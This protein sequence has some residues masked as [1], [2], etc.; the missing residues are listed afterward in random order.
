M[1]KNKEGRLLIFVTRT[2]EDGAFGKFYVLRVVLRRGT[3]GCCVV[4]ALQIPGFT[5]VRP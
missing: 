2:L 1:R 3:A 5:S 4:L